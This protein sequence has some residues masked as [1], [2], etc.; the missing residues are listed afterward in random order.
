MAPVKPPF[1]VLGLN[2]SEE[3]D[4]I[5]AQLGYCSQE[6]ILFG[7]LTARE[8][9]ELFAYLKDVMTDDESMKA[10]VDSLS[11]NECMDLLPKQMS[12]GQQRKLSVA[13]AFVGDSRLVILD[14]PTSS[15]DRKNCMLLND[16]VA[17]LTCFPHV[18]IS[19]QHVWDLVQRF[20]TN[21]TVILR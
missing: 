13:L 10:I 1:A 4:D 17:L 21:R 20:K 9:L 18:A 14:E 7:E 2:L 3:L 16:S 5:R 11:L 8:H 6:N 12:G 19:K 15:L